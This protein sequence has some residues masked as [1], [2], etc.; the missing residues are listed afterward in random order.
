ME[1]G[2]GGVGTDLFIE[3]DL[4]VQ[5]LG[6]ES[7]EI[8]DLLVVVGFKLG[9]CRV[10]NG[11]AQSSNIVILLQKRSSNWKSNEGLLKSSRHQEL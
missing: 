2:V 7:V 8:C 3:L 5:V 6:R 1:G 9:H 4:T 10:Q 11:L